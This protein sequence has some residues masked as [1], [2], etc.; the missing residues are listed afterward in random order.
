[1]T[2]TT[3]NLKTVEPQGSGG[4]NPSPSAS[5]APGANLMFFGSKEARGQ[6]LTS[7]TARR[8]S[9]T[10]PRYVS[11]FRPVSS[12]LPERPVL[13]RVHRIACIASTH[14][15]PTERNLAVFNDLLVR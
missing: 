4:S 3:Q 8:R 11:D 1:M 7:F 2:R 14:L 6:G 10:S 13:C 12:A 5:R 15:C 9:G